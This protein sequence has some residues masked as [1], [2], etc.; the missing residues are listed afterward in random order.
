M[1]NILSVQSWVAYGYVGNT[2]A[3]FPLQRLGFNVWAVHTVMFS[4]H[5]G[6][7]S[8]KGQ[9]FEPQLISNVIQGIKERGQHPDA[10]LSGY[11]G[12][13]AIGD[14]IVSTVQQEKQTNPSFL[15]CCN[16]VMGNSENGCFVKP[17]ISDFFQ[18][19]ALPWVDILTPNQ[20]ELE[21]ITNQKIISLDDALQAID[22]VLEK[23]PRIVFLTGLKRPDSEANTIE[24]IAATKTQAF[25]IKTPQFPL[26]VNGAG[27]IATALF[28]GQF[29][30]SNEISISLQKTA[31]AMYALL[32][33][34]H[35][36]KSRE[37]ELIRSQYDLINPVQ[38]FPFSQIR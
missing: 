14:V 24:M 32:Q 1:R 6:Y 27:D 23:G 15:Y 20:F 17:G 5:T 28:L 29:L 38:I 3:I 26:V 13:A 19:K 34:T 12:D 21:F 8:W 30:Q 36:S 4:N 37:I 9:G 10:M 31:S 11:L 7:G 16:P 35:E 18:N 22:I 25:F 33:K 2:A